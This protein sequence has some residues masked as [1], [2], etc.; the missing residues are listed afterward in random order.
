MADGDQLQDRR[1]L[2]AFVER[3]WREL[4]L[5]EARSLGAEVVDR[6][7]AAAPQVNSTLTY[8]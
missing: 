4:T 7:S 1:A 3:H 8:R 6:K 2:L 5:R